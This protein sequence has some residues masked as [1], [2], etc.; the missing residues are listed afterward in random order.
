MND[1]QVNTEE[2]E[3]D[4]R[5]REAAENAT[6]DGMPV[7]AEEKKRDTESTRSLTTQRW[8]RHSGNARR[9]WIFTGLRRNS[10]L[11]RHT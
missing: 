11:I 2:L 5:R 1:D 8:I 3:E 10:I 6:D 9:N 7:V 4:R